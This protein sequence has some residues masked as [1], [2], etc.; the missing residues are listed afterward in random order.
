MKLLAATAWGVI[1]LLFSPQAYAVTKILDVRYWSAPDHTR[2][3]LDLS[4][5]ASYEPCA[6]SDSQ[7]IA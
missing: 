2:I 5:P 1:F 6:P 4:R 3:V 7:T